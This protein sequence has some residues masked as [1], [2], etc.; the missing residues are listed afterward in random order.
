MFLKVGDDLFFR[1]FL[2]GGGVGVLSQV[3]PALVQVLICDAE[4]FVDGTCFG[5]RSDSKIG[6][7]SPQKQIAAGNEAVFSPSVKRL[8]RGC[9]VCTR[10]VG[11]K[12]LSCEAPL[13]RG[14]W[15]IFSGG[16]RAIGHGEIG[17]VR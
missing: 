15:T 4:D 13:L 3:E 17:K 12:R 7:S 1:D 16:F 10:G 9:N 11:W 5:V 14:S 6:E 8:Q 2:P